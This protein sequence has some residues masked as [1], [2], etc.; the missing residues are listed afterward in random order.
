[1]IN[2]QP[3]QQHQLLIE[4]VGRL[5]SG[6]D[7]EKEKMCEASEVRLMEGGERERVKKKKG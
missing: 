2:N 5:V 7:H 1:M 6:R 4:R 3:H